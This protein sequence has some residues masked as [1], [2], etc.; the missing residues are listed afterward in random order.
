TDPPFAH[1]V[2]GDDI[3]LFQRTLRDH[4]RR[5]MEAELAREREIELLESDPFNPEAQ[6]KIEE[7]IRQKQI[8]ENMEAAIEHN[9]E[10]FGRVVMLYVDAEVNR[11]PLKAFVDS[12]AQSTI[13]SL[14]CAE[15]CGIARLMDKRFSGIAKGVGTGR[16]MGRVHVAPL[17]LGNNYYPCSFTIIDQPDVEFLFGL[18]ML[19]KHQCQIDLKAN[20]LRVGGGE[21]EVPFLQ[22]K[23]LPP[24]MRGIEVSDD[25][26][27]QMAPSSSTAS[28]QRP[29]SAPAQGVASS[30]VRHVPAAAAPPSPARPAPSPSGPASTHSSMEEKI[31]RL[32]ELGFDHD[33]VVE[34]LTLFAGNEQAAASF[35]FGG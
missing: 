26:P 16:I 4:H 30:P 20:V 7:V 15:R 29:Q 19:R 5:T 34:A 23:D 2:L 6:R 18:D 8:D 9:P 28:P 32:K 27:H 10:A 31:A 17:K 12:G 1:A 33:A 3:D 35:L 13:M 14:T 21:V 25:L 24:H 11:V 22:E